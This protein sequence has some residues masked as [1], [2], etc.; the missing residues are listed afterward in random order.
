MDGGQGSRRPRPALGCSAIVEE[1][2]LSVQE[3]PSPY[4]FSFPAFMIP[5]Q[6]DVKHWKEIVWEVPLAAAALSVHVIIMVGYRNYI[7]YSR[8]HY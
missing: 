3:I 2:T 7:F 5:V 4:V 1:L 8:Y 6:L